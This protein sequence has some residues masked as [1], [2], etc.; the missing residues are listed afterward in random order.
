MFNCSIILKGQDF[1]KKE[2]NKVYEP[3]QVEDRIYKFWLDGNMFRA[4]PDPEK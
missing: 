2:L 4:D 3:S 1:M